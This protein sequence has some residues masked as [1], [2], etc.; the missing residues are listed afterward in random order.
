MEL[1]KEL[2]R[3]AHKH[4]EFRKDL[5]PLIAVKGSL[6]KESAGLPRDFDLE[7]NPIKEMKLISGFKR[8][9]DNKD[10]RLKASVRMIRLH[11]VMCMV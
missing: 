3:L 11:C 5:F 8:D 4:P 7:S 9:G 2:I 1:R 6:S 10:H